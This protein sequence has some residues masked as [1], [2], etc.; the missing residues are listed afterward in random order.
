MLLLLFP[1]LVLSHLIGDFSLQTNHMVE[2][3]S[4]KPWFKSTLPVHTGIHLI[5]GFLFSIPYCTYHHQWVACILISPII[6]LVHFFIDTIK[7]NIEEKIDNNGGIEWFLDSLVVRTNTSNKTISTT[8]GLRLTRLCLFV[9]DQVMHVLVIIGVLFIFEPSSM[10]YTQEFILKIVAGHAVDLTPLERILSICLLGF[11]ATVVSSVIVQIL[12][13]PAP[14]N[15]EYI[16]DRKRTLTETYGTGTQPPQEQK[17]ETSYAIE[18]SQTIPRGRLIGYLERLIVV[19]IVCIGAYTVIPF[20]VAA[21]S[22]ARFKKFDNQ[23]WAE[24]FLVG[25]LS[26]ILCGTLS[27]F[28]LRTLLNVHS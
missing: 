25:T 24:Y 20:I 9:A 8:Q 23:E 10:V 5:L 17:T 7:V 19:V 2:L 14:T 6:A 15:T 22:L 18:S 26:S 21:K 11:Y 3:K 16:I 4:I 1:L 13:Y 28:V 12:T 27:G